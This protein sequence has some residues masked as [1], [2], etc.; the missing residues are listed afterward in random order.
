MFSDE[1]IQRAI[2]IRQQIHQH[3]ELQFE[4]H[5]T[6]QLVVD[7]LSA[8]GYTIRIGVGGT[9][10]IAEMQGGAVGT[11]GMSPSRTIA[12][13]ADMDALPIV[14]T[15]DLPYRST[16]PGVMHAC[17]HDGHTASLLLAAGRIAQ[18]MPGLS[19]T[20]RLLFQPA[21][22]SAQGAL[23]MIADGAID[24][25]DAIFGFHNRPGLAEGEIAV[26]PGATCGGGDHFRFIL[27]GRSGHSSRPHLS[28]DLIYISTL[29]IQ[30]WQAIVA[31]ALSPLASGVVSVTS[32]T[33]G[34]AQARGVLPSECELGVNVRY[35]SPETRTVI[36]KHLERIADG[37]CDAWGVQ[38]SFELLSSTPAVVNDPALAHLVHNTLSATLSEGKTRWLSSLPTLGGE[39]FAF[40]TEKIP[41][42]LFFVGAG[43]RH[44]DLHTEGYDF[45]DATLAVAAQAFVEITRTYLELVP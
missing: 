21:E 45:C 32:I 5:A 4:E 39:D 13:R 33:A 8:L 16:R 26:R 44:P 37:I 7:E 23:R 3:P 25:V 29:I 17:G 20:V 38:H 24:G 14:E 40:F 1:E 31:R 15:S 19:G 10:V 18:L 2:C 9:G 30:A 11:P 22:E 43:E 35:D 28:S 42:C 41:G 27:R 36:V 34:S 6:A 12:L